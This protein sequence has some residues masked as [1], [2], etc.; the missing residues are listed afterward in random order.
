MLAENTI[1]ML[2]YHSDSPGFDSWQVS[3]HFFSQITFIKHFITFEQASTFKIK[4]YIYF[5]ILKLI[6][7]YLLNYFNLMKISGKLKHRAKARFQLLKALLLTMQN[8]PKLF[9][10]TI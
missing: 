5:L 2:G 3:G 6:L 8:E 10:N 4:I 9:I 1:R 7:K